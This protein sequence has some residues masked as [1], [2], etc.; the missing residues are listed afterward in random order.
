LK[1]LDD[2]IWYIGTKPGEILRASIFVINIFSIDQI[3]MIPE[4][5]MPFF[6]D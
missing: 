2:K 1:H 3:K 6:K 4:K 5:G